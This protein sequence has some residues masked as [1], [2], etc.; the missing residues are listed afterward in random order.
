MADQILSLL[1]LLALAIAGWRLFRLRWSRRVR[2]L[3]GVLLVALT[4]ML[5]LLPAVL[6]PR[7]GFADLQ[8]AI[9]VGM[10]TAGTV[11]LLA[12]VGIAW[13]GQRGRKA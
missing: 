10:L 13:L 7:S 8:V 1:Y 6:N 5:F 2:I 11:A 4:P 12:G 9:G 3:A